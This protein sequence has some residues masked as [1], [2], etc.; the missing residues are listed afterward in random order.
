MKTPRA[1]LVATAIPLLL[2]SL[3]VTAGELAFNAPATEE[4]R[5]SAPLLHQAARVLHDSP[6]GAIS[7]LWLFPTADAHT[8]F[9]RYNLT[10]SATEHLTVLTLR[11]NRVVE[12]RELTS[13]TTESVSKDSAH[14]DWSAA[15]GTGHAAH[16]DMTNSSHGVPA[17]PHWTANIGTGAAVTSTV[18]VRDTKQPS[19]TDA[20]PVV[21]ATAHWTTRIGRGDT[22][23]SSRQVVNASL[24]NAR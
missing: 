24:A 9:A 12:S 6:P 17:S 4:A 16:A 3:R 10:G 14:L 8:V 11:D 18:D 22:V 19:S 1:A 5:Q 15:I 23:D 13:P 7:N 2:T 20:H 21:V